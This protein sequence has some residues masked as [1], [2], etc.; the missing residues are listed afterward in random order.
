MN[1]TLYK[2]T[3]TTGSVFEDD[4]DTRKTTETIVVVSEEQQT[5][6]QDHKISMYENQ[7]YSNQFDS[8]KIGELC[9]DDLYLLYKQLQEMDK[10]GVFNIYKEKEEN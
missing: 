5:E 2:E 1:Y 9:I 4:S 7:D 6:Y 8:Q 3:L 10:T